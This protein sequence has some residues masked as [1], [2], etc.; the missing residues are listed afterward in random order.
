M[1]IVYK[2]FKIKVTLSSCQLKGLNI[3]GNKKEQFRKESFVLPVFKEVREQNQVAGRKVVFIAKVG[4]VNC[5][6]NDE[7]S[8]A[9]YKV[10]VLPSEEDLYTGSRFVAQVTGEVDYS[11]NDIRELEKHLVTSPVNHIE[12]LYSVDATS[13]APEV[14]ALLELREELARMNL[15]A[16]F[17]SA[18]G[19]YKNGL[20]SMKR[21]TGA[22]AELV[23]KHGYCTK[24]FLLAY[25]SLDFLIG[26]H[27][28]GF[29]SYEQA[30]RYSDERRSEML[31]LKYGSHTKE[32][33]EN[34][35]EMLLEQVQAIKSDYRSKPLNEGTQSKMR[36][37]LMKLV[38]NNVKGE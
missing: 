36:K 24:S 15:P 4:S 17:D 30:F 10:Y 22:T 18:V 9:D 14:D 37:Q 34:V 28:N 16:L 29:S 27:E 6:L 35:L 12:I 13:L 19:R 31:R 25:R 38:I 3:L 32:E 20:G 8:D 23:E 1:T 5:N 26:Y 7:L 11:V 33:A 2:W 21:G